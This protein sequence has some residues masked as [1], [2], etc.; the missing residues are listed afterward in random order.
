MA[1]LLE[2]ESISKSFGGVK[3][4]QDVSMRVAQ[5]AIHGIIGPNGAGKTTFFNILSGL[6]SPDGGRLL[7]EG[8][9]IAGLA[10]HAV[11]KAGIA[12]TFQNLML[13]GALSVL[14]NVMVGQH[15]RTP[16]LPLAIL[17]N[18]SAARKVEDTA[19]QVAR[20]MLDLVG[21]SGLEGERA[22]SLAYGQRRLLEIARAMATR[23]RLLLLDEP[24]AG[25]NPTE[26][27]NLLQLIKRI[28]DRGVTII[29]IEHDMKL[30]M[31][32]CDRITVLDHGQKIAEGTPAEV[33]H[34]PDVIRA[35]LGKGAAAHG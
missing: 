3:A 31:E 27:Q 34:H 18:L 10:P 35:Y 11:C 24:A 19:R 16:T 15:S 17:L 20:E 26:K 25:M 1:A 29:L 9:N 30:V 12:R 6:I 32:I 33:R 23:P 21:L 28:R 8:R 5:G 7:F 22:S 13:F 4:V 2:A 14:E